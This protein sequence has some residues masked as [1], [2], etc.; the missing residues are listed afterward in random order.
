MQGQLRRPSSRQSHRRAFLNT[1]RCKL[2]SFPGQQTFEPR[3][4]LLGWRTPLAAA[5]LFLA[6]LV[7]SP[8]LYAQEAGTV[9]GRVTDATTA[10]PLASAQVSIAELG[11]GALTQQNGRFILVN[12]PAGTHTVTV[13]RI[14]YRNG[15]SAVTVTVGEATNVDFAIEE[16]AL[17]LDEIIVTGTPGGTQRR[18]LGN[19]VAQ[20]EAADVVERSTITDMQELLSARAPGLTFQTNNGN[21]GAGSQIQIRGVSSL[22]LGAQPLIYVDGVRIDNSANKGPALGNSEGA[23]SSLNDFNPQDIESIEVI[24][25]PAAATLYGTEASAGVIQII[26]K[27]GL[28]GAP[29]FNLMIR[30]GGNFMR[31]PAGVL[32]TKYA[33]PDTAIIPESGRAC[34]EADLL[35]YNAYE[36]ANDWVRQENWNGQDEI[37]QMGHAQGYNLSVRGGTDQV[38]YFLSGDYSNDEGVLYYNWDKAVRLRGNVSVLFTEDLTIDVS[39]GYTQGESRF[40]DVPGEGNIFHDLVW[41]R[42]NSS[43]SEDPATIFNDRLPYASEKVESLRNYNRFT[44]SATASYNWNWLTQ[45]LIVGLDKSWDTNSRL[46]PLDPAG[47]YEGSYDDETGTGGVLFYGRPSTTNATFDYAAT[48]DYQPTDA[49]TFTTSVGA[50]YYF[51]ELEEITNTGRAFGTNLQTTLNQTAIDQLTLTF[52]DVQNKSLGVYFQEQVGWADRIFLTGAIRADDNS[53]F[54]SGFDLEYYPKV[55]LA[56]V[57]SEES[58][59]PAGAPINSLRLRGAWGKAGRQ[60]DTFAGV[61]TYT[62]FQGPAGPGITPFTPGNENVG[63]EVSTEIELG[64]DFALFDDRVSGEFTYYDQTV[65]DALVNQGIAPSLGVPGD[66][67]LN[68]GELAVSGWEAT[69]SSR[70]YQSDNVAF[71]LNLSGDHTQNE[72]VSLGEGVLESDNFQLGFPYPNVT[73]TYLDSAAVLNTG[74]YGNAWCDRGTPEGRPGGESVPCSDLQGFETSLLYGPAYPTYNFAIAPTLTLFND[75]QLFALA[76]GEYGRWV[77]DVNTQYAGVYRNTRAAQ[78][79]TDPLYLAGNAVGDERYLGRVPADHWKLREVGARY[80]LP[81]SL[82]QRMGADRASISFSGRDLLMLWQK[83]KTDLGGQKILD[84]ETAG[85]TTASANTALWTMPSLASVSATLRV[86]F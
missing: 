72:I 46:I 17:A 63:P 48:A 28:S 25:G 53:A 81:Q 27:K 80:N 69:L 36:I 82:V 5:A 41:S 78:L 79:R 54:G 18:A 51:E 71:D 3:Q 37:L 2:G 19:S 35:S 70:L 85:P 62:S 8:T 20:V 31:D 43:I 61:T 32:G 6:A 76:D 86:S 68:L 44:G 7:S 34:R 45:R 16:E 22:E 74:V 15:T 58:F 56:W 4:S 40:A 39:T 52:E 65:N 12:V 73:G 59:W 55:S 75:L 38:R 50:Q 30:Q 24:K 29:E 57:L 49:L 47:N 10:Q 42:Y 60:P 64:V 13:Q 14:G 23:A 66:V 26:T 11:V 9:T 83:S 67:S 84:V 77:A 33:C 1:R 21:V